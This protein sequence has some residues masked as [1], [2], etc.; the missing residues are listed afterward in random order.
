MSF[1]NELFAHEATDGV[2]RPRRLTHTCSISHILRRKQQHACIRA[3]FP[4][5][6]MQFIHY[7]GEV[8]NIYSILQQIYS[9]SG[10][11]I[12]PE[13]PEFYRRY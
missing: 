8:E 1:E 2:Y 7:L 13:S 6:N 12:L 11:Q 3:H 5:P 4:L 9:N 10:Y